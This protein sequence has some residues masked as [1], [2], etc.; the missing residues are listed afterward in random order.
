[1]SDKMKKKV[2]KEVKDLQESLIFHLTNYKT[3]KAVHH[4]TI[5]KY[6]AEMV[7]K[8]KELSN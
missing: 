7:E 1:M 6:I 3:L 4:A 8:L 2:S 5:D